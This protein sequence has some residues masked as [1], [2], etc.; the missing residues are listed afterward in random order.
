LAEVHSPFQFMFL[1]LSSFCSIVLLTCD[2]FNPNV[3]LLE[4]GMGN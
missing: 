3:N 1:T 4:G 2:N